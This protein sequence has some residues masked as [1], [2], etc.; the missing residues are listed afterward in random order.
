M[1][2]DGVARAGRYAGSAGERGDVAVA[3]LLG[4]RDG[5]NVERMGERVGGGDHAGELAFF[6]VAGCVGLAVDA[7]IL[8][9]VVDAG[10]GRED[11]AWA[12][13]GAVE[14]GIVGGGVD[15]RLEDGAGGA[16]G[17]GMVELRGAVVA[18]ADQGEIWPVWGSSA[19]RATCG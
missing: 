4:K 5:G 8:R 18:A 1:A 3:D 17:G 19:T 6:E 11:A 15:E 2:T 12:E 9:V 16:L 7:E 14:R 13:R 10:D